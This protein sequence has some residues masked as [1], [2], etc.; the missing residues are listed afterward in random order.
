[1]QRNEAAYFGCGVRSLIR[2]RQVTIANPESEHHPNAPFPFLTCPYLIVT[3]HLKRARRS[4]P[5]SPFG[6][7]RAAG[8]RFTREIL[9]ATID[10]FVHSTAGALVT[11]APWPQC[12]PRCLCRGYSGIIRSGRFTTRCFRPLTRRVRTTRKFSRS[13][14]R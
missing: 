10:S 13:S 8:N 6:N 12:L 11:V 9:I 14:A 1:M 3:I 4:S 2:F 7:I 5:I